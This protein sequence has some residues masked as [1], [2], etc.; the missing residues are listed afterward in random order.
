MCDISWTPALT[1]SKALTR[2]EYQLT[3]I[4]PLCK[5]MRKLFASLFHLPSSQLS[6]VPF[7][8]PTSFFRALLEHTYHCL[9]LLLLHKSAMR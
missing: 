1:P 3:T 7:V 6:L 4:R 8:H 2:L 5:F 9:F